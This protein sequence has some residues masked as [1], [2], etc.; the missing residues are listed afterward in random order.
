MKEVLRQQHLNLS[1]S[2][3]HQLLIYLS[4]DLN[5]LFSLGK[6]YPWPR[7]ERCPS[8]FGNRLWS[9]GYAARNFDGFAKAL[10]VKKY[11]C[12]DCRSVHTIRPTGY[13]SFVQASVFKIYFSLAIKII[14]GFWFLD[15]CSRR[16]RYWLFTFKRKICRPGNVDYDDPVAM[17]NALTSA[18]ILF[19]K[20]LPFWLVYFLTNYFSQALH[21]PFPVTDCGPSP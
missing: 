10:W 14:F 7:P 2:E 8:C 21:L 11:R 15:F 19:E 6:E 9:H 17:F 18:F 20:S 16:Q 5:E 1:Y 13:M 12:P 4:V 3:I